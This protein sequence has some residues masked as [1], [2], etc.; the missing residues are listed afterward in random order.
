MSFIEGSLY[1][2]IISN[3][4]ILCVD[5]IIEYKKR[6]LL[7]KRKYE[8]LKG[9]WWVPG[10]RVEIGELTEESC[11][12][13]IFEELGFNVNEDLK[14]YGLYEDKFDKSSMGNHLYHTVSFVY[15]LDLNENPGIKVDETSSDWSFF[16]ELPERFVKNLRRV[17]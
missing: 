2:E 17:Y 16:E 6:F 5:I 13:K 3:I 10:G 15:K 8:P 1:K 11:K 9:N 14:L 7:V 4:P 12:R